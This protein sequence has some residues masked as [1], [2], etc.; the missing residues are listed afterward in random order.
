MKYRNTVVLAE[1]L[2]AAAGTEII[3]LNLQDV[4]S[5]LT[6]GYRLKLNTAAMS[7]HPVANITRIELV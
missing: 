7:A 5:R 3:P 4:I 2:E 6:I 1:K